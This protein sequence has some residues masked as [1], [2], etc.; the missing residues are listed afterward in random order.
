MLIAWK[1]P[2]VMIRIVSADLSRAVELH[3]RTWALWNAPC[4]IMTFLPLDSRYD[5]TFGT[6]SIYWI[7][8]ASAIVLPSMESS[9][10]YFISESLNFR[11]VSMNRVFII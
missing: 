9:S 3:P 6:R 5:F 8:A 11:L 2:S 4:L 1:V 7:V 10:S